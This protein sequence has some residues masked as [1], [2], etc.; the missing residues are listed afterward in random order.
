MCDEA[1][2]ALWL[3]GNRRGYAVQ[4]KQEARMGNKVIEIEQ[5][6]EEL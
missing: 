5:A 6:I 1:R 2:A 3:M 4:A